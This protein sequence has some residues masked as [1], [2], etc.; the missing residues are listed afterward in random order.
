V[1]CLTG[2]L[3]HASLGTGNQRACDRSEIEVAALYL[4]MLR[5][6]GVKV[7]FFV[8]GRA[9]REEWGALR[10]ICEDPLVE[11]GGHGYRCFEPALAH[12]LSKKLLGSYAG[13]RFYERFDVMRT[14]EA[15][16]QRTGR[17]LR[18]WRNHMYMHGPATD[19]ILAS[20][21]IVGCSDTVRRG[22]TGPRW[23]P[24]GLVDVPINVLPDHEHI[25]HAERT[26]EWVE[27]WLARYHWSDDFGPESYSIEEW[28]ERVLATLRENEARGAVSTLIVHPIT[29]YLA[30]RFRG[31][32][33]ILDLLASRETV[34]MG[35]LVEAALRARV[36]GGP[37]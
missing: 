6:A 29:M 32:R 7:T 25:Y 11:L 17:T 34:H 31:I 14:L 22:A 12:R 2:D 23:R 24:E 18:L 21:G 37:S 19:R 33:R 13:P 36:A 20:S 3:H 30:D 9:F 5:D 8:T 28:T 4:A 27:A 26:H 35:E 15:A 16:R 10:P 1:I